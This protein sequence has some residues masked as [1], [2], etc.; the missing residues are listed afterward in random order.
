MNLIFLLC[1]EINFREMKIVILILLIIKEV[2]L[3]IHCELFFFY[4]VRKVFLCIVDRN[5]SYY[6][7]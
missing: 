1:I 4:F 7:F 3:D 5:V 6:S 2:N